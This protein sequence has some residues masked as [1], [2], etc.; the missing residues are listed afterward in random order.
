MVEWTGKPAY[1]QVAE[2]LR[3]RI[4][5]DEFAA[6]GKLPSLAALMKEYSITTTVARDAIRQLNR[7][8]LVVSH[9]GKGAF[10]TSDAVDTARGPEDV[11]ELRAEV[12]K[13]RS[14]VGELRER[15]AEL[16]TS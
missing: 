4:A 12:A 11:A 6:S 8:G 7:D 3:K 15:V 2:K 13:L 9:Q 1:Q 5:A 14:E 10:L 16:E